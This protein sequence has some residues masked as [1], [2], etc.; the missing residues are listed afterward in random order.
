M[1]APLEVPVGIAVVRLGNRVLVGERPPGTAY[2][3]Y[4]EF[5]GGKCLP[6]EL[7][8]ACAAR[9]CLEETGVEVR[10][11]QS[12]GTFIHQYPHGLLRLAFFECVPTNEPTPRAPFRWV[13]RT[14]LATL[15]FPEANE[16][17]LRVL[18]NEQR[19]S[20]T[21]GKAGLRP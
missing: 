3:G 15:R 13:D 7:P 4:A 19:V 17:V 16:E 1:S 12:L 9:E 11:V 10:V 6:D 18:M 2:A 20:C 8:E 5:P 14:E 21:P